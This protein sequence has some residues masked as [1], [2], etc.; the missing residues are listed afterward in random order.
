MTAQEA[1]CHVSLEKNPEGVSYK[2]TQG[3]QDYL[4]AIVNIF[5]ILL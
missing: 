2:R 1:N 5:Q 4:M 3:A